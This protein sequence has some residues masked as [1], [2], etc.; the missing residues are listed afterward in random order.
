WNFC[1]TFLDTHG[2]YDDNVHAFAQ[3]VVR[4]F[5]RDFLRLLQHRPEMDTTAAVQ[6]PPVSGVD[7]IAPNRIAA[8]A[9]IPPTPF[10]LRKLVRLCEEL[11]ICYRNEC[12]FAVAILTRA[13]LD[14]VPPVFGY[15]NFVEV[16][17][18]YPWPRSQKDALSHLENS[19]RKIADLHLHTSATTVPL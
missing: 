8:L 7:F 9:A 1:H 16:V 15:R 19:A 18:N 3:H 17:N 5:A 14:Y 11:N 4:P 6:R 13:V 12:F 2:K 10:D